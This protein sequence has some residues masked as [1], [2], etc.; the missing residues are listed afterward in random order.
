[1]NTQEALNFLKKGGKKAHIGEIRTF[2]GRPH[3]KTASGWK[4][5]GKGTGK[6]ASAHEESH[7]SA[8]G[9][10]PGYE[11][12]KRGDKRS[13]KDG[14]LH[15]YEGQP[16][17]IGL[18]GD[19]QWH[20]DGKLH[21]ENGMPAVVLPS[22]KEEYWENGKKLTNSTDIDAIDLTSHQADLLSSKIEQMIENVDFYEDNLETIADNFNMRFVDGESFLAGLSKN[23]NKYLGAVKE[24]VGEKY[25]NKVVPKKNKVERI[26]KTNS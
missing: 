8:S 24:V 17:V 10:H 9:N 3:I 6:K 11:T 19:K 20:K 14:K 13:Y 21:R 25:F 26:K 22:G 23:P 5:Y 16:S 1:M 15:S 12:D 7:K 2:A 4:F 18:A